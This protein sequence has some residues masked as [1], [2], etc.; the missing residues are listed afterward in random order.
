MQHCTSFCIT[1]SQREF[2]P[3]FLVAQHY[4]HITSALNHIKS[5][6][7]PNS[8]KTCTTLGRNGSH[9]RWIQRI[10]AF[11]LQRQ[12][13]SLFLLSLG[14]VSTILAVALPIWVCWVRSYIN[15]TFSFQHICLPHW[16]YCIQRPCARVSGHQHRSGRLLS[17][18]PVHTSSMVCFLFFPH[19]LNFCT[20]PQIS[21]LFITVY[22]LIFCF[23][24]SVIQRHEVTAEL[25][26]STFEFFCH[27]SNRI[28]TP[29]KQGGLGEMKIPLL[30][31]LTHQI[32][33]DYGV[34]LEDQG[35]TLR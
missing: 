15:T 17:G 11:W 9:Q 21:W 28:N 16:D 23:P 22:H 20:K 13:S 33:K 30:S 5:F 8:L 6:F 18:L 7:S 25:C 34:Y 1:Y 27:F 35:H 32:S 12:I 19:S 2:S 4:V 3:L 26:R 24:F 10:E 31:D 14:F 29:R